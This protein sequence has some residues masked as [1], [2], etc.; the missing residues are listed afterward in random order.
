MKKITMLLLA[1]VMSFVLCACGNEE[2]PEDQTSVND[3]V[4]ED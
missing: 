4:V 1:L 2:Q 3:V